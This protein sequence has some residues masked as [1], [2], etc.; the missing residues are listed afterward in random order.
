MHP[1]PGWWKN[2][3]LHF[4]LIELRLGRGPIARGD[5]IFIAMQSMEKLFGIIGK[6]VKLQTVLFLISL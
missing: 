3:E 1:I 4:M 5:K 6:F 2:W